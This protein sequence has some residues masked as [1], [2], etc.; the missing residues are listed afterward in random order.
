MNL[1]N[2]DVRMKRQIRAFKREKSKALLFEDINTC[3]KNIS[4][5][6][7]PN[8]EALLT[9]TAS[10]SHFFKRVTVHPERDVETV[11]VID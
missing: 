6:S 10:E 8:R 3:T 7:S 5:S 9:F 4:R 2:A 11:R 1:A